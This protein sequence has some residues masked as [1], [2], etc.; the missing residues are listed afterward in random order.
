MEQNDNELYFSMKYSDD[1]VDLFMNFKEIEKNNGLSILCK[2]SSAYDIEE[3][4]YKHVDIED[5]YI[6]ESEEEENNL[7]NI[8]DD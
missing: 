2:S 1:I 8:I 7:D 6:D 4:L 5:P 3:F